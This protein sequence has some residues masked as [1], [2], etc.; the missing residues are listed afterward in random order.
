MAHEIYN[1]SLSVP[2]SDSIA[3]NACTSELLQLFTCHNVYHNLVLIFFVCNQL[4][5]PD[6]WNQLR[7]LLIQE[8]EVPSD[9]QNTVV[10]SSA[11]AHC[12]INAAAYGDEMYCLVLD[13]NPLDCWECNPVIKFVPASGEGSYPATQLP[14]TRHLLGIEANAAQSTIV[15]GHFM[16]TDPGS[17]I[18]VDI[19]AVGEDYK[20]TL[21]QSY[22]TGTTCSG[23]E[24][25]GTFASPVKDEYI[26]L[27]GDLSND[28]FF[29]TFSVKKISTNPDRTATTFKRTSVED[30]QLHFQTLSELF[31]TADNSVYICHAYAVGHKHPTCLAVLVKQAQLDS[32]AEPRILF[33]T[34]I[35]LPLTLCFKV[36]DVLDG[37]SVQYPAVIA[38]MKQISDG[39][40]CL[41]R[42]SIN[43]CEFPASVGTTDNSDCTV[44]PA[45]GMTPITNTISGTASCANTIHQYVYLLLSFPSDTVLDMY[46]PAKYEKCAIDVRGRC[47]VRFAAKRVAAKRV[48]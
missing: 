39:S 5:M 33:H 44:V 8:A 14:E 7:E 45:A 26:V 24:L 20:V 10:T 4:K 22:S 13:R 34:V 18:C 30:F 9:S 19:Y 27:W 12:L 28:A 31:P 1:T 15:M 37:S 47:I 32:H 21:M 36:E 3:A 40:V 23:S 35:K 29:D 46:I 42:V 2:I 38:Q 41:V 16:Y 43:I 11:I 25:L 48:A 17:A 6:L